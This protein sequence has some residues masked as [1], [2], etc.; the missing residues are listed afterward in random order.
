MRYY[1]AHCECYHVVCY[2]PG[3]LPHQSSQSML[4]EFS[5]QVAKGMKYLSGK[6]FVHRDLAARNILVGDNNIC[7]VVE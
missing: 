5:I 4:Y 2:R 1:H 6:K 7:K 3:E